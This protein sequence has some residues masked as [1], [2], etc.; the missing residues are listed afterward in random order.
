MSLADLSESELELLKKH[1]TNAVKKLETMS[2]EEKE[3][4]A[5]Q[6]ERENELLRKDAA[7]AVKELETKSDEEKE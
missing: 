4:L 7:D 3:E 5:K 1:V 2:D 6:Y